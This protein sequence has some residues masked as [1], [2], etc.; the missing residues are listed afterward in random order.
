MTPVGGHR[1]S[2]TPNPRTRLTLDGPFGDHTG[3][4]EHLRAEEECVARSIPKSLARLGAVNCIARV[5]SQRVR[6]R[7]VCSWVGYAKPP[8]LLVGSVL[9]PI[10]LLATMTA[11]H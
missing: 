6:E 7:Q 2:R 1:A 10:H 3:D 8:A 11:Q 4:D 9:C 5:A